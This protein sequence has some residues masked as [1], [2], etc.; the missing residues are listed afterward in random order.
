MPESHKEAAFKARYDKLNTAQKEAVDTIYGPVMVIAGPGTGKTEVL[1]MRIARLLQSDAQVQPQEIL[2]LTYT[3]EATNAM[4]RRLV[5]IIGPEG[6]KVQ[7]NTFH[8][9]CNGIIQAQ[10]DY[11]STLDL[12]PISD[13]DRLELM[14]SLIDELPEGHAFRRLS[15]DIYA[16]VKY[17]SRLFAFMKEEDWTPTEIS[18][19]VDRYITSLPENPEFQYQRNTKTAKKGDPKQNEINAVTR[20]MEKTR[21]A[22]LLFDDYIARMQKGGFYDFSDMIRW[23]LQALK[24][25]PALLEMYQERFQFILVDE[26]QDTN[27]SQSELLYTL[28]Q[29]WQD[30]NLFVVGD[31]DQSIY[32][33]QGARLRN[34]LDF[35]S[36]YEEAGVRLIVLKENYRSTQAILDR[37]AATIARNQQRLVNQLTKLHLDKHIVSRN[38]RFKGKKAPTPIVRQYTTEQEEASDIV[39]QIEALKNS[40]V[41]LHE[42]AVIYAQHKQSDRMIALMERKGIPFTVKRAQSVLDLPLIESVI[43]ILR[44][45]HLERKEPCSAEY[46][47]FEILHS[48]WMEI[49]PT[50]LAQIALY[51]AALPRKQRTQW[52]FLLNNPLLLEPSDTSDETLVTPEKLHLKTAPAILR[53]AACLEQ[54]L[55]QINL[56]PLPLLLE[57]IIYESGLI[58]FLSKRKEFIWELQALHSFFNFVGSTNIGG[59]EA[60]GDLLDTIDKMKAEKI[61]L[62]MEKLIQ[63]DNGVRFTTAHGAKGAEFEHVFLIGCNSKF[64]EKKVGNNKDAKLPP[65]ITA[66]VES[67]KESSAKEEVAR[68]LFYVALTRAKQ[69]LHV[70]FNETTPEGQKSLNPSCFIDEIS[71]PEERLRGTASPEQMVVDLSLLVQPVPG[72]NVAIAHKAW[73]SH[74]LQNFTMS[75]SSL[76]KFLRCPIAFYYESVLKVPV[77]NGPALGFGTAVHYALEHFFKDMLSNGSVFP[78]VEELIRYFEKKMFAQRDEML[79]DDFDRRM[80]QGRKVLAEYYEAKKDTW[81]TNVIIEHMV[82][83]FQLDGV[84]VTGKLDKLELNGNICCVVDYKTGNPDSNYATNNLK[85]P[86]ENNPEGGDY[87]RQMVFYKML[88][89]RAPD[90]R[91]QMEEGRF[92]YVERSRFTGDWKS[93]IMP[94][95]EWDETLVRQ[96]IRMAYTNI[97]NHDFKPG[98]GKEDCHWCNFAKRYELIRPE[99]T[100]DVEKP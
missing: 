59:K 99:E 3:D 22:A 55:Q 36:R 8:G 72:P 23:V 35:Y 80:E 57:K 89:E 87:W 53:A 38:D 94:V 79:P 62:V 6:N 76:S 51:L 90:A 67:E 65:E 28:T 33:F 30:P 43:A 58:D 92:E 68:R 97:M 1:S 71:T 21:A 77:L 100:E 82:P 75:Y 18:D 37:A 25:Q 60:L 40:G 66:A 63:Q 52:R 42:V 4:R 10:P 19:A 81:D 91:W 14:R 13:L 7:V 15:G 74:A 50:D 44:Y 95:F 12:E 56:L 86:S 45:L 84:P 64:W 34:I 85:P 88:I 16:D 29:Y 61:P 17:L 31:D 39:L 5:Q 46:L 2:C 70:S 78:P 27:G 98:C 49:D 69:F 96:Q 48:P 83:R 11:F 41:P 24:E 32:E 20:Q 26:F 93:V 73:V 9:F 54:W 47:L